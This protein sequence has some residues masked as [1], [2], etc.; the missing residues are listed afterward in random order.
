MCRG[1]KS[2]LRYLFLFTT[3]VLWN[4]RFEACSS[5]VGQG[6]ENGGSGRYFFGEAQRLNPP[7]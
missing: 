7:G 6:G 1:F 4:R 3:F 2:L 5:L